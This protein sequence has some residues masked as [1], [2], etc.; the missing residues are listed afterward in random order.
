MGRQFRIDA[1]EARLE[2]IRKAVC[3]HPELH[4][5]LS[6]IQ[7][8]LESMDEC[9]KGAIYGLRAAAESVRK[10]MEGT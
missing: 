2:R 10:I 1:L 7:L 6:D 5:E 9:K 3:E 8:L 4:K